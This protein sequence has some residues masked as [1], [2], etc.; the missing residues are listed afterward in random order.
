MAITPLP[1]PPLPSDSTA[2][3]N[4]KAFSWVESLSDFTSEAN[5]LAVEVDNNADTASSAASTATTKAGEALTSANN[6]S[7]SASTATTKA[8]EALASANSAAASLDSFDDRYLGSKSSAPTL[9]NDGNALLEGALYWDS[10]SKTMNVYNGSSWIVI[11]LPALN[12]SMATFLGTPTSAN[13]AL[14]VTNETGSGALVFATSPT[15]VSPALGTPSSGTVTNLTGTASINI[16]GTVGVSSPST[17]SFTTLAASSPASFSAGSASL[18]AITRTGDTNTGMWF[19]DADTIAFSEGGV[20]AM[21][22]DSSGRLLIGVTSIPPDASNA[23]GKVFVPNEGACVL[24]SYTSSTGSDVVHNYFLNPNGA[25]GSISTGGSSTTYSTSSDY[26][27]K[28]NVLPMT[29]ALNLIKELKPVTYTWKVD[30]SNGQGFIAHELQSVVP[31]CV[32]GEKDAV[33]EDGNPKYQGVDTSFLVATLVAAIQ[34][35][36]AELDNLKLELNK[37]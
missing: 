37:V 5:S 19:P 36:K 30:G 7:A 35:L 20:E 29:G 14:A 15:L 24:R 3:F 28:E 27:L 2:E 6:A 34:E 10:V 21:R 17:G 22:I 25:V 23:I 1:S 33:D 9:D 26:R 11:Y 8:G 16:N 12:A 32:I 31:D 13:L 18:P 4:A